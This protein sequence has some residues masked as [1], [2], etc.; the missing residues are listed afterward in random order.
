M[1][2]ISMKHETFRSVSI[3]LFMAS[4]KHP[5][6]TL[7][8]RQ[9]SPNGAGSSHSFSLRP[10]LRTARC[11]NISIIHSLPGNAVISVRIHVRLQF[12][13]TELSVNYLGIKLQR[14]YR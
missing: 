2:A 8:V 1:F 10:N 12:S 4:K 5:T 7:L 9:W 14:G 13:A 11:G 3:V 6:I